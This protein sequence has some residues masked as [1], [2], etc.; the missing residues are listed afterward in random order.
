MQSR[1]SRTHN[2]D[3]ASKQLKNESI[4]AVNVIK[5]L[6][7]M[8]I[9][10]L[11]FLMR[12]ACSDPKMQSTRTSPFTTCK[13]DVVSLE[14]SV[15]RAAN[16]HRIKTRTRANR[17]NQAPLPDVP[18]EPRNTGGREWLQQILS[19]FG[20]MTD[21]SPNTFVLDFEKPLVELD[22]RIKEV[23]CIPTTIFCTKYD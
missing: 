21:R 9:S 8:F 16:A 10:D 17:G 3:E 15:S 18:K 4:S 23:T 1:Q 13:R 14:K 20:P 6:L 11:L 7:R 12:L 19:K 22:N 2:F 5:L